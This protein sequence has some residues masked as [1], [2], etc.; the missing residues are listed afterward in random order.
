MENVHCSYASPCRLD[1]IWKPQLT[2]LQRA[3]LVWSLDV[4]MFCGISCATVKSGLQHKQLLYSLHPTSCIE[5]I[6]II[7]RKPW[8]WP[9][10]P[11]CRKGMIP[12]SI[13]I[14]SHLRKAL[15]IWQL[16]KR[17]LWILRL[18]F[19]LPGAGHS[20]CGGKVCATVAHCYF[21]ILQSPY[22]V[23]VADNR[24]WTP[25]E[26]YPLWMNHLNSSTSDFCFPPLSACRYQVWTE[27]SKLF[28][29]PH[30]APHTR[31]S[32]G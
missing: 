8:D 11:L 3:A 14:P 31:G 2:S 28:Y 21:N 29:S 7:P 25:Y 10:A 5:T 26:T 18:S 22:M 32:V 15:P 12:I 30:L 24:F 19:E 4:E 23:E 16:D 13:S 20:F 17:G 9:Y 27:L 1:P 6:T